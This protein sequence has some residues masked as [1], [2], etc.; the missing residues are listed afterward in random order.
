MLTLEVPAD[1]YVQVWSPNHKPEDSEHD[2]LKTYDG[3][4]RSSS[5]RP[6]ARRRFPKTPAPKDPDEDGEGR[7]LPSV[8]WTTFHNWSEVGDWYRRLA[9]KQA[10]PNDAL[11]ARA[12]DITAKAQTP[13]D[14]IRAIYDF[15]SAHTRYV[16]IDFGIG[17]YQPH[18]ASE[19]LADQY[20][21]CKDKDTL[22]E[23][24]LRAKGF[25]TAPALIGAG[26]AP[27]P[28]VPSPSMFNHVITTVNLP[29]GQIWLDSTPMVRPT[30][31]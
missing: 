15:V 25:T 5:P 18:T 13:E 7:K 19:V 8:E 6:K 2:G 20:G 27:V 10:E 28:E 1:K 26:I 30:V 9:L 29:S 31:I 14:Q 4:S 22:L 23:A 3:M 21:D 17:R 11:R 16:G 24:L 12:N